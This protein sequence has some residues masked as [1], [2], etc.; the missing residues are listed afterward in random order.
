L[1]WKMCLSFHLRSLFS[2][3]GYYRKILFSS[4]LEKTYSG[5]K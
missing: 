4:N 2:L 1:L 3:Y 5:C